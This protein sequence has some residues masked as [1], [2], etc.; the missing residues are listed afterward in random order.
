VN[1]A[2]T[3]NN[4][5]AIRSRLRVLIAGIMPQLTP[6]ANFDSW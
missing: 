4:A 2:P 5:K 1:T 3:T 6:H